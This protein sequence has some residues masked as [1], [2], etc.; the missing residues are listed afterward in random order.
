MNPPLS[1]Q[2]P[3]ALALGWTLLHFLWQG[4]LVAAVLALADALFQ[5]AGA[6]LRYGLACG[7]MALM[8]LWSAGTFSRLWFGPTTEPFQPVLACAP[9]NSPD[10]VTE[11]A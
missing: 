3:L 7:A 11:P 5:K 6:R 8:A 4:A 1:L 2:E 9:R 10:E